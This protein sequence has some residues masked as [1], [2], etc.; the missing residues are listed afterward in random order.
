MS[1][2]KIAHSCLYARVVITV[3]MCKAV[4]FCEQEEDFRRMV[5]LEPFF[6]RKGCLVQKKSVFLG[7]LNILMELKS[8]FFYKLCVCVRSILDK[9]NNF[10]SPTLHLFPLLSIF[11]IFSSS[12]GPLCPAVTSLPGRDKRCLKC[13]A[14][15]CKVERNVMINVI[16][17]N[18]V[19]LL[20]PPPPPLPLT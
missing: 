10:C 1:L 17:I 14:G 20:S 16:C 15:H 2:R 13:N 3:T 5:A 7:K 4:I 8:F 12:L 18:G 11:S 6:V 19:R 9:S